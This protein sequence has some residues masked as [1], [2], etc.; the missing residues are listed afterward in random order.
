MLLVDSEGAP[1]LNRT[2]RMNSSP[3][4]EALRLLRTSREKSCGQ[5]R[6]NDGKH[7]YLRARKAWHLRHACR[8]A[9]LSVASHEAVLSGDL[10]D[11]MLPGLERFTHAFLGSVEAG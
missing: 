6:G 7:E 1:S 5:V 11:L 4:S 10:V 8:P 3:C 9:R 2:I